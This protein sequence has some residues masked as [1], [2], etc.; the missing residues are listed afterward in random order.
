MKEQ[1]KLS[2]IFFR[3]KN[4]ASGSFENLTF[5]DL[6]EEQQDKMMEDRPKEWLKS[7]AKS[8]ATT[9]NNIGN[10]FDLIVAYNE[11]VEGMDYNITKEEDES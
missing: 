3:V 7:L 9:I 5:E 1:R 4:E 6:T 11:E 10:K 2:G 8:L